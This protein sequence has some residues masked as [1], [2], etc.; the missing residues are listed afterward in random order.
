MDLQHLRL[1][2]IQGNEP[3]RHGMETGTLNPEQL[4]ILEGLTTWGF[5]LQEVGVLGCASD[6]AYNEVLDTGVRVIGSGLPDT[7]E[8]ILRRLAD[9]CPTHLVIDVP[10]PALFRWATR[11]QVRCVGM[12]RDN[13]REPG[14]KQRWDNYQLSKALNHAGVDWVGGLG[15]DKCESLAQ[16]GVLRDKLIPW[17]WPPSNRAESFEPKQLS[18]RPNPLQLTYVG[19]LFSTRGI[20]ALLVATAQ[21]KGQGW[22]IHLKLVGQGDRQRFEIQ[23]KRLQ[24]D[25]VEFIDHVPDHSLV[26][27][28]RQADVVVMPSRHESPENSNALLNHCLQAHTP[29]VASDHPMFAGSLSHG[30]NA[31]IFPAGNARAL[32]KSIDYLLTHPDTYGKLSAASQASWQSMQLPVHWLSLLEHWLQG[33][34]RHWLQQ[35]A[36]SAPLYQRQ[37]PSPLLQ[38]S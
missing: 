31:M 9:F 2:L 33:A 36:L 38:P 17:D 6:E 4:T 26:Y 27:L 12:F 13:P 34:E 18:E 28:V 19:P 29:I 22:N 3:Y 24:L 7:N 35:Y 30:V 14:L 32:S 8:S 1:L 15:I 23:A 25:H 21:L 11:Q 37:Q 5:Q 16:I 10:D 20:G